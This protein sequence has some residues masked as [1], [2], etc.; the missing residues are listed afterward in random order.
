MAALECEVCASHPCQCPPHLKKL[1]GKPGV[2]R[3]ESQAGLEKPD[4][5]WIRCNPESKLLSC[6]VC[7]PENRCRQPRHNNKLAFALMGLTQDAANGNIEPE[8]VGHRLRNVAEGPD[9]ND[10]YKNGRTGSEMHPM[11]AEAV[12]AWEQARRRRTHQQSLRSALASQVGD[13]GAS[14]V[15]SRKREAWTPETAEHVAAGKKRRELQRQG[16]LDAEAAPSGCEMPGGSPG[17]P[18]PDED[19][20]ALDLDVVLD[21]LAGMDDSPVDTRG[22]LEEPPK[23]ATQK[24]DKFKRSSGSAAGTEHS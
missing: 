11:L 21:E 6:I 19:L 1:L 4:K 16:F 5:C 20:V 24:T 14:P 2:G 15:S 3:Y 18:V 8:S 9:A 7:C 17:T 10:L 22:I 12:W 23:S 13:D